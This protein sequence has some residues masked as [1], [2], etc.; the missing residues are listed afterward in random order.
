MRCTLAISCVL[1][2]SATTLFAQDSNGSQR[3][4]LQFIRQNEDWSNFKASEDAS[5]FDRL[6]RIDLSD[7]GDVWVGF[8]GRADAR[9]EAWDGFGFGATTPGNSDEFLLT[10]AI[11][12]SDLHVG[13]DLRFWLEL[14][15]AQV[16]GR[17]QLP[18][19]RRGLD[20]DTAAVYQAF[21]DW[22]VVP[23]NDERDS[24]LRVRLGR[25]AFLFG[26]QRFVSPLPWANTLRTWD[27]ISA[28]F[29]TGAWEINGFLSYFVPIQKR[30]FNDSNDDLEFY[31]VYATKKPVDGGRGYDFFLLGNT[32]PNVNI[33][34]TTG[35]ERRH[36]LGMRTWG[37]LGEIAGGKVD[38][39][40]E[41]AYQFGEVGSADV[42][43]YSVTGVV[44]YTPKE[45]KFSPRF[46]LGVDAASGDSSAGGD[47]GTFHQL[48]PL[49]HAYLGL[50]DAFGRQN[51]F[52]VNI[53]AALELAKATRLQIVA[54][55]FSALE[56]NDGFY[57][58]GG[59]RARTGAVGSSD[60]GQEIDILV[61]H[62]FNGH[63]SA[64]GGYSYLIAGDGISNTGPDSNQSFFY[65]GA[66][67]VF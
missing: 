30:S 26:K 50:A 13:K 65:L 46:F 12:H 24:S 19:R 29:K 53:G 1:L 38:A 16:L 66:A 48:F 9:L 7:D 49:G 41:G 25:Q 21:A 63:V 42:S 57:T 54:H 5:I 40:F 51:I 14:K 47:V 64:Y 58:V 20:L 67:A 18:G 39:E 4:K 37:G 44:G 35:N 2:A 33:N 28:L 36:T 32:R 15:T 52:A 55:S 31:G 10:R 11:V 8:G 43:A 61:N 62:K 60:L 3:P 22:Y 56:T 45:M 17:D 27:G 6:K 23:G 59:G 34:G